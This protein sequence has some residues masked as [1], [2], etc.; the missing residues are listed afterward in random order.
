MEGDEVV[1]MYVKHLDS[2][3]D[4]PSEELR[5]FKRVT[6]KPGETKTVEIPL[7]AESLAYWDESKHSFVVEQDKVRIMIGSSS[8]DIKLG[9]TIPVVGGD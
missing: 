2:H 4:R 8:A 1:Q 3:V 9:K 7:N 6:L 5:G